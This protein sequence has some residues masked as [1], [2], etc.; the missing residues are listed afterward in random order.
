MFGA[1]FVM[2]A[3]C[4]TSIIQ[5]SCF[6]YLRTAQDSSSDQAP[7]S[8]PNFSPEDFLFDDDW[9]KSNLTRTR[10]SERSF[11]DW[12]LRDAGDIFNDPEDFNSIECSYTFGDPEFASHNSQGSDG[13]PEQ[14]PE[15]D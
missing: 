14:D 9:T 7:F 5:N 15:A 8:G 11:I 4:F 1:G 2:L 12:Q 13:E 3:A 6:S 10:Y